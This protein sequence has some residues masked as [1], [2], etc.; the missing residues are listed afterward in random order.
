MRRSGDTI[1][2]RIPSARLAQPR[3][4]AE[5]ACRLLSDRAAYATGG[6]FVVDGGYPAG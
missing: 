2:A 6:E 3:E 4:I 1:M 5:M